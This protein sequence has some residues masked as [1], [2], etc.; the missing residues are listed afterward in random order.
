MA[1]I[2]V[3]Y[4]YTN[5]LSRSV[6]TDV[7]GSARAIRCMTYI[8]VLY[9]YTYVLSRSVYT[10]VQGSARVIRCMT[11]QRDK[12]S[13]NCRAVLFDEEV[14]VCWVCRAARMLPCV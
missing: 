10:A 2:H 3:L 13:V 6:Y 7:Q 4:T 12:L 1:Y 5:V 9:M 11:R 8:H 14:S